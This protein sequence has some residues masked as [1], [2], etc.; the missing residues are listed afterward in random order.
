M[1]ENL[2]LEQLKKYS[3]MAADAFMDDPLYKCAVKNEKKRREVIYHRTLSRLNVSK[4]TD[5]FYF[6]E[7]DRG[8]LIL[9]DVNTPYSAEQFKDTPNILNLLLLLPYVTKVS[10]ISGRFDNKKFMD[11]K[12]YIVSPIFVAKEHQKKGVGMKL[13]KKAIEDARAKGYKL[14]L[15]TQNPDNVPF[16]EKAGFKV[17]GYEFYEKEQIHNYYMICE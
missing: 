12:T 1:A 4:K 3:G 8:L 15:D 2:T 13:L 9:R 10:T 5:M 6:D 16:Y 11:D 7:E 14:G 17:V